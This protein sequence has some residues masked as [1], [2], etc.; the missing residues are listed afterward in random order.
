MISILE[1]A[2]IHICRSREVNGWK[3]LL[4]CQKYPG[5]KRGVY[6]RKGKLVDIL[7][8]ISEVAS[9]KNTCGKRINTRGRS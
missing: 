8:H 9:H 2:V 3:K 1:L 7:C 6:G 5:P 4:E